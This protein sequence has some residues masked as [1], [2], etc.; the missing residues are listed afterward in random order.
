MRLAAFETS[1]GDIEGLASLLVH[2]PA[3]N[4]SDRDF[5]QALFELAKLSRRFK[6]AEAFARV[7]GRAP[8]VQAVS[9][10]VGLAS[11][12]Q[13]LHRSFE[14]TNSE[15]KEAQK[16][17]EALLRVIEDQDVDANVQLAALAYAIERLSEDAK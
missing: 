2:K 13:P 12:E 14:V 6:E 10:M 16:I 9:V 7:K 17:S 15:L 3:R 4:W 8:T 5:E 11:L 1:D